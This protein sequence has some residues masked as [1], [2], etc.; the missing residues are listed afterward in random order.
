MSKQMS[1]SLLNEA[2][3]LDL[4]AQSDLYGGPKG[5][6]LEGVEAPVPSK[7]S[8]EVTLQAMLEARFL[9]AGTGGEG[10]FPTHPSAA[11]GQLCAKFE[12]D[13]PFVD[14]KATGRLAKN[15]SDR[16]LYPSQRQLRRRRERHPQS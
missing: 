1:K 11:M 14:A 16:R 2:D 9:D 3:S 13:N 6:A 10:Y 15:K 4:R 8:L 7:L 12:R 5:H